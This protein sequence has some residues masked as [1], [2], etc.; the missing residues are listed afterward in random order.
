MIEDLHRRLTYTLLTMSSLTTMFLLGHNVVYA[1]YLYLVKCVLMMAHRVYDFSRTKNIYYMTEFCYTVHA[2]MF[3]FF[4]TKHFYPEHHPEWLG[5]P[6]YCLAMGPLLFAIIF[7][8]D[9]LYVHSI[10]HHISVFIH[11]TPAMLMWK[12]YW[13]TDAISIPETGPLFADGF[14]NSHWIYIPWMMAYVLVHV[15][16]KEHIV[17]GAYNTMYTLTQVPLYRYVPYHIFSYSVTI[18]LGAMQ[19][20]NYTLNTVIVLLIA[21]LAVWGG[22]RVVRKIPHKNAK[23]VKNE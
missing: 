11:L 14:H 9:R 2:C 16:H 21:F 4:L 22:S 23:K 17:E 10:P 19:R 6:L 8:R 1:E 5:E 18:R 15:C 7:N 20:F 12:L 13:Y 3:Y